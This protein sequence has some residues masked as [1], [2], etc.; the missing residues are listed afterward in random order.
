[1]KILSIVL[2]LLLLSCG[3]NPDNS[4]SDIYDNSID[5]ETNNKTY[6]LGSITSNRPNENKAFI[7]MGSSRKLVKVGDP[8]K[9]FTVTKI[10]SQHITLNNGI[11]EIKKELSSLNIVDNGYV[12]GEKRKIS[13]WENI[14]KKSILTGFAQ[15]IKIDEE[16]V[17]E[18]FESTKVKEVYKQNVISY[19]I[20]AKKN[21]I[22]SV[23]VGGYI[24]DYVDSYNNCYG[25]GT[26]DMTCDFIDIMADLD[27]YL[28]VI[29]ENNVKEI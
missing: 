15:K 18:F 11:Y 3:E 26:I 7:L 1:M 14:Y 25:E 24:S 28:S 5:I 12:T 20:R 21:K 29:E 6:F 2:Y 16:L 17:T 22:H 8:L 9:G 23:V 4:S 27:L 10:T 13:V 19:L